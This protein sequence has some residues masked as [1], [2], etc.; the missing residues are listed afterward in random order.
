[1]LIAAGGDLVRRCGRDRRVIAVLGKTVAS[2]LF[3]A[4]H[5]FCASPACLACERLRE[6]GVIVNNYR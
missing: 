4:L 1:M 6:T 5:L 2:L 3:S